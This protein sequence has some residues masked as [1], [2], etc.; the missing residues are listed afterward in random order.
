[1]NT[2]TKYL[3]AIPTTA[4]MLFC[5]YLGVANMPERSIVSTKKVGG[6]V[7]TLGTKTALDVSW[8]EK[9]NPYYQ[10]IAVNERIASEVNI[11]HGF[12]S[13]I[14]EESQD[15]DPRYAKVVDKYFWDLA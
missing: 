4:A 11:I 1:M 10:F 2:N 7:F 3:T 12:V 6:I 13:K 15:L 8:G 14:L 5:S 9:S